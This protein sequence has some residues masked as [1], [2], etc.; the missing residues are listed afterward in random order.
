MKSLIS[1][2]LKLV[3]REDSKKKKKVYRETLSNTIRHTIFHIVHTKNKGN[4][5]VKSQFQG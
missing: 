2:P 5:D 1:F 3:Y 4:H